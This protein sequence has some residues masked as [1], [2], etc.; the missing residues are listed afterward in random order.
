[1]DRF[2]LFLD[3]LGQ[4]DFEEFANLNPDVDMPV[5]NYAKKQASDLASLMANTDFVR[6]S[7]TYLSILIYAV[8]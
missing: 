8:N 1:M 2:I 5:E 4:Y 7:R 3:E 6:F